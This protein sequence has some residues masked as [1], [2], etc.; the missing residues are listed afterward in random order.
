MP[1]NSASGLSQQVGQPRPAQAANASHNRKGDFFRTYSIGGLSLKLRG[2]ARDVDCGTELDQF[3]VNS[4][5][6]EI[7]V[8]IRWIDELPPLGPQPAFDSG[9]TWRLFHVDGENVFEFTSPLIGDLPY[10][11]LRIDRSF[12]RAE[13]VLSRAPL[14]RH[15]GI[16][17]IEY[18]VLELLVTNYLAHHGQGIEVHGCGLIDA[19]TRGHLF[20][21]HSGAGKSTTAGLWQKHRSAEILSDDRLILRMHEGAVWMYGTPWHGEAEFASPSRAKLNRIYILQ[22]G[23]Q[24]QFFPV[25]PGL[26]VAEV[27]ARSFPPFHSPEGLAQTVEFLKRALE[28]VHVYDFHFL[29]DHTSINAVLDLPGVRRP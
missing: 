26:A 24:N 14:K 18:P 4:G 22:H 6:S 25:A 28:C 9:A 13:L 3:R 20:L 12:A 1:C 11:Q 21:G 15:G 2:A 16:S 7:Q 10:K 17:A 19:E 5:G 8:N 27:F 29:P 23:R